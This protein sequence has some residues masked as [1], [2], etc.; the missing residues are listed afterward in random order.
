MEGMKQ[1]RVLLTVVV[2]VFIPSV[3]IL[4]ASAGSPC[5]HVGPSREAI[6]VCNKNYCWI[7]PGTRLR[8]EALFSDARAL[9]DAGVI[10]V[11]KPIAIRPAK[12]RKR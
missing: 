2:M 4:P 8:F 10:G 3:I 9:T 5:A 1:M 7:E 11:W 12:L 6:C